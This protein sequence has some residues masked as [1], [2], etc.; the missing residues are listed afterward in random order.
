MM[1][2][3]NKRDIRC[4]VV[5]DMRF[6]VYSNVEMLGLNYPIILIILM[7]ESNVQLLIKHLREKFGENVN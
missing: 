7:K 4:V 6:P 5:T 2:L 3:F 1:K